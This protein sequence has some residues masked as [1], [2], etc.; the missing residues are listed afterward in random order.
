MDEW[1]GF[2]SHSAGTRL[3]EDPPSL[4]L[5]PWL[6]TAQ[7]LEQAGS[8]AEIPQ[9]MPG[10]ASE[11]GREGQRCQRSRSRLG[12]RKAALGSAVSFPCAS[13]VIPPWCSCREGMETLP[14]QFGIV[15]FTARPPRLGWSWVGTLGSPGREGSSRWILPQSQSSSHCGRVGK[16]SGDT[17][18]Q[19]RRSSQSKAVLEPTR[20]AAEM[21]WEGSRSSPSSPAQQDLALEHSRALATTVQ[22]SHS[23]RAEQGHSRDVSMQVDP[24]GSGSCGATPQ[25][26][27]G[28]QR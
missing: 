24:V 25:P 9:D 26:H 22:P 10:W 5:L 4:A 1:P 6:F 2:A 7:V 15:S 17:A 12:S 14:E 13:L 21:P 3:E 8:G 20:G 28:N 19:L 16:P 23:P 27:W 11:A 18:V